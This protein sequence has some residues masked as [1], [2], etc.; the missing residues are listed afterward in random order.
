MYPVH[1]GSMFYYSRSCR[2]C[3]FDSR[4]FHLTFQV[5]QPYFSDQSLP[6]IHLDKTY[7]A[8]DQSQGMLLLAMLKKRHGGNLC[9][10]FMTRSQPPW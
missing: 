3:H 6:P 10:L 2:L 1:P 8:P 5:R 9:F 4:A 7:G